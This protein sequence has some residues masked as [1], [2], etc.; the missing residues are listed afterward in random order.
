MTI[1]SIWNPPHLST[2]T[3]CGGFVFAVLGVHVARLVVRDP[4]VDAGKWSARR[5][6]QSLFVALVFLALVWGLPRLASVLMKA[7]GGANTPI[8]MVVF[9]L[10]LLS[11][12]LILGR[13]DGQHRRWLE[14]TAVGLAAS[15]GVVILLGAWIIGVGMVFLGPGLN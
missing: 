2:V 7:F 11:F 10:G 3:Y 12:A 13:I 15:F 5:L 8:V 1:D 14:R 6:S 9:G 4:I